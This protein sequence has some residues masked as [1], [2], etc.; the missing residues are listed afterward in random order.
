VSKCVGMGDLPARGQPGRSARPLIRAA[1]AAHLLPRGEKGRGRDRRCLLV[2]LACGLILAANA[3][4]AAETPADRQVLYRGAILIDGKGGAERPGMAILTRGERIETIARAADLPAPAGAKIVDV[5]GLYVLPGLINSHEHLATPPDRPAAEANLRKDLYGGVTAVRDMADDLR[6]VADLAR[7]A[8]VG[9]IAAPD[10]YYAALMAG[11]E[12]FEDPRTHE[13]TRGAVA[14]AVPWMQAVTS[15]TDL[16]IAVAEARGTGA[17]GVKIYAD[18]PG[19][20]VAA[21]TAEAHRQGVLVWAHAAVFPASPAEVIGAG[22]DTVSHTCLLAYQASDAMPRAYHHRPAVDEAR[23]AA[24]DT[25]VIE[26]LLK[27]MRRRGTILD[28]TLW[29]Y[30][31]MERDHAADPEGP[32]PYCG[33][34][35]A[36]RLTNEA[37]RDGVLISTGTDGFSDARDPWPSLGDELAL[38]QDKAGMKPADVIRAATVV[39]AMTIGQQKEMGTLEPGK[40]ANMVFTARDPLADVGALLWV[41]LTVKRGVAYWRRD[42]QGQSGE[43]R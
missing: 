38:L 7:A 15:A 6:Q 35:L 21:I 42:Y 28:A 23:F 5:A 37:W 25:P 40:L 3:S 18:L 26:A 32:A 30:A 33:A 36:E 29:V 41:T 39:G 9:E 14:G 20:L 34:G 24:G 2:A 27:E 16:R 1:L 22:V 10:I 19:S 12:F 13:T 43:R 8:R 11:P 31:E 4:P 17:T